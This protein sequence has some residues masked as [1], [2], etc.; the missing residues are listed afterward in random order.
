MFKKTLIDQVKQGIVKTLFMSVKTRPVYK[1]TVYSM[2]LPTC[3]SGL[4]TFSL[5]TRLVA[6]AIFPHRAVTEKRL[7]GEG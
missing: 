7:A 5:L 1:F 2:C 6:Q 3:L 4:L